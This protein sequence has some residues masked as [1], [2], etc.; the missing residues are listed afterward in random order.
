MIGR[1]NM[2]SMVDFYSND[3]DNI[4]DINN[5]TFHGYN[6][7]MIITKVHINIQNHPMGILNSY[8]HAH[9]HIFYNDED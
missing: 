3:L 5:H 4:I 2:L 1:V 8:P 6:N 9:Y 7:A